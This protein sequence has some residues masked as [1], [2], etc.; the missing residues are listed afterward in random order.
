MIDQGMKPVKKMKER[1]RM[2]RLRMKETAA[3]T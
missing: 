2:I 3:K 1:L